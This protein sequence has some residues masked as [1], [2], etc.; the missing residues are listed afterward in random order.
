MK[1]KECNIKFEQYEFNNKYCKGIECQTA[2]AV[3]LLEQK[4]KK[5]KQAWQIEKKAIKERNGWST[6]K[7]PKNVLQD[8][9]NKLV[10]MIDNK[11][12]FHCISCNTK[13]EVVQYAGGHRISVGANL[14][15]RYNLHNIHK[16]CNK[17][18]NQQLSGNPDGYDEGLIERYGRVYKNFV[19]YELRKTHDYIDLGSIDYPEKIKLV[20]KIIKD[21]DTFKFT[22]SINA[23]IILNTLIGIYP[24]DVGEIDFAEDEENELNKL[25]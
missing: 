20:R 18:C 4:K 13:S 17:R 9:V 24:S 25:F 11:F 21:F 19:K 7:P 22:S 15:T 3:H 10:R 5:D 6:T 23:R 2:K 1:C 14:S 8:E 12:L 16:Q